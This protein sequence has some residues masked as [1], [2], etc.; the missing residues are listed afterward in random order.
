MGSS[1][2]EHRSPELSGALEI[3]S[4]IMRIALLQI[5]FRK[6]LT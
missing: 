5:Q 1:A 6:G 4:S 2:P 3:K